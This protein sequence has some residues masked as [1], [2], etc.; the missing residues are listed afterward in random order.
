RYN[1]EPDA[2]VASWWDYGY[3]ITTV[4]NKTSLADNATLN[5]TQ[6]KRIGL[7]FMSPETDAVKILTEFNQQG[8]SRG[9]S[10]SSTYVL[11]FFTFDGQGSDIGYGEESKWRW[12]ANIANDNLDAWRSYGNY[13]LGRDWVDANQNGQPDQEDQFPDN[14]KGQETTLY[15]LMMW[16]KK[17][18]VQVD[19]TEPTYFKLVYWS[20]KGQSQVV[21][22]GGIHALVT[23]WKVLL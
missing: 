8:R 10:A 13:T 7:M 9:F 12:M 18:R 5:L 22:A 15:K 14:L 3:W 17:Q 6:I 19:A 2:V 21:T 20:Q 1:L 16:G 11:A 23:I 4:A